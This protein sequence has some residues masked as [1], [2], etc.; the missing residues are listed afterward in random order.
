MRSLVETMDANKLILFTNLFWGSVAVLHLDY[1][2]MF[3]HA[4]AIINPLIE[5]LNW[6][7]RAIQ[8]IFVASAP[9]EW[10]PPW[11]GLQLVR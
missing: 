5:R 4:L 8:N 2:E 11:V 6:N 9:K 7:D 1:E 3:N 10:N